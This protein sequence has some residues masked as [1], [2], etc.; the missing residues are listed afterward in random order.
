MTDGINLHYFIHSG[1]DYGLVIPGSVSFNESSSRS[2]VVIQ[3]VDDFLFED[4]E[5]ISATLE[6][7][8]TSERISLH[9]NVTRI[10]IFDDDRKFVGSINRNLIKKMLICIELCFLVYRKDEIYLWQ[11]HYA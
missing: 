7:P 1:K 3:I 2:C 11:L 4:T 10:Q 5:E 6:L 8:S 9:P